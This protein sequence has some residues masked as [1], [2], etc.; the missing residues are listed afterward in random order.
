MRAPNPP[1][2]KKKKKHS[3]GAGSKQDF[4]LRVRVSA[5]RNFLV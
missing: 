5:G 1:R 3:P 4:T 2:K